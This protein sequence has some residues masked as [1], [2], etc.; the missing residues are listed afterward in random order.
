MVCTNDTIKL[1]DSRKSVRVFTEQPIDQGI[2]KAIIESAFG[3]P[4]AG[5]QML[6]T[7]IDVTSQALKERLAVT[8]D[9]QPFIGRA[10]L[11]L[12]FLADCR[13][14]LDAYRVAGVPAR[15]PSYGDMLLAYADACIAAQSTVIAAE[16]FGIGSCYIG[17]ILE[18]AEVHK[19]LLGLD[20]YVV[21]ACMLV[22]GYPTEEQKKRTKPARFDYE[23][24]VQTDKYE[25]LSEPA[26]REMFT[27]R[28]EKGGTKDFDF[29]AFIE[30][31]CKRKYMSGFSKE[32]SR[33]AGVYLKSFANDPS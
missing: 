4:T 30:A 9:N 2:K 20:D 7:I 12:I 21:P 29:D 27:R 24:I 6:Y 22:Y 17:D 8:C 26:I 14:W 31:F 19:E 1:L 15:E 28:A 13:K 5:A 33:S 23:Y 10:P 32:M 25:R 3:S 11:V 16:S 18:N